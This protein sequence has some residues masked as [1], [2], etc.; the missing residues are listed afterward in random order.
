MTLIDAITRVFRSNGI[1]RGDTDAPTSLS[2]LQHGATIQLAVIG[3]QD[4]LNDLTSDNLIAYEHDATGSITTVVGTRSYSL[5]SDFIR[6][7]GT[8]SLYDGTSNIR[9]YEYPGGEQRLQQNFT[10]YKTTQSKPQYFYF[11][12]TT[13]KK[14]AFWPVPSTAETYS[15]DY[16]KDVSVSAAGD[17][18]PFHNEQE[19]QAF[20]RL[21]SRRFKMIYEGMDPAL[22]IVDPERNA[23]K[24]TLIQLMRGK[25]PVPRYAPI[26]SR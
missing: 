7:F 12:L 3:I 21:A 4:E 17:T 1:I 13:T 19:A 20:C 26:Y 18:L 22:I 15:F 2:D 5:P 24:A 23:A 10:D 11:D 8:P 9:I 16:E 25:N 14:L 6:F